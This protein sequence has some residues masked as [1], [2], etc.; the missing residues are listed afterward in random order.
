[1]Q[2]YQM[3]R[4]NFLLVFLLLLLTS[5]SWSRE[6]AAG[7]LQ[8]SWTD[9]STNEDGFT[10]ERKTG[11]TGT[12]AQITTVGADVTSYTDSGLIDGA[13]YCYGVAAFNSAGS[14]PYFSEVCAPA[15]STIQNFT[16]LVTR[17]GNGGGTVTSTPVG[18]NCGSSCSGTYNSGT[19]VALTAAATAGSVFAGW[20]G[21]TDCT[22][23]SVTM[24]A[25][26][27]CTATF[28]LQAP[29]TYGL[30]VSK[31]GTGSGTVTST[32]V[33]INCG[34]DC[35]EPY[36]S[37]T[38]VTLSATPV[39]GST[40]AGWSAS[41][42]D[43]FSMTANKTCTAVFN[44]QTVTTYA[45]TVT[46]TGTGSGTVTSTD[47]GINC[48]N[49]CSKGYNSGTAVQL[50]ATA[51][52]G[53]TFTGWS[54]PSCN[55]FTMSANKNCTAIFDSSNQQVA[56][57]IGIFRPS[58]GQWFLDRN[59]NG[60]LDDCT[61]DICVP[62]YGQEGMLPVVGDWVVKGKSNIGTFD[63]TTGAWHLD[64]GSFTWDTCETDSATCISSFGQTG[65]LPVVKESKNSDQ[66]TIGIYRPQSSTNTG[67]GRGT[68][69]RFTNKPSRWEFDA[70][71]D[72]NLGSCTTDSCF[73]F[74]VSGDL[75]VVGDWNGAGA[76]KI[77]VFRPSLGQWF[78]D[79]NGNDKWDGS[80]SD[81]ILGPFGSLG[82]RPVVGDWDG[83]GKAKIGVF[84]PNSGQW[85]LDING[86]GKLDD[87]TVDACLGPFG[88]EGDLPVVGKW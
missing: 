74:G 81:T 34:S 82:D 55:T 66:V 60:I 77:G 59:G 84:R 25:N 85:F 20:T 5:L 88:H 54:A 67:G 24:I 50:N 61:I 48:G 12:Y 63:P 45:L 9:N 64:H 47:G 78:L 46:K 27:N 18:L 41:G 11:T 70:N 79:L 56:I 23:G 52:D 49:S 36:P 37:G 21:D 14:S 32:P 35:S 42:C 62:R 38:S 75:P 53:S 4:E 44:Q 17:S 39:E 72:A 57:R 71:G 7:E 80:P 65:D 10:I 58:T 8:L 3:I 15:R 69:Q 1:M 16:L 28:N 22:D 83:T 26:R 19:V 30:T 73:D 6:T 33:G 13:T 87:C 2:F 76:D 29:A 86:N 51:G 43:T 40:F 68:K 31:A